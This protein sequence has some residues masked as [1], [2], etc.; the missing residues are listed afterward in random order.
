MLAIDV[1][2]KH[3]NKRIFTN[4]SVWCSDF[5]K[6]VAVGLGKTAGAR[7]A[8]SNDIDYFVGVGVPGALVCVLGVEVR[9]CTKCVRV[10]LYEFSE[11]LFA[12]GV[13]DC[14]DG[15]SA[16]ANGGEGTPKPIGVGFD[17]DCLFGN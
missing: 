3:I 11:R 13:D 10:E 12:G 15:D 1:D 14:A 5:N 8:L 6:L 2:T 7:R 9:F 16:R 17:G 4:W